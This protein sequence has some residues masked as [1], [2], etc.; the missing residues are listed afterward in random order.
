MIQRSAFLLLIPFLVALAA[1][2][3]PTRPSDPPTWAALTTGATHTCGLSSQGVA[4]CWGNNRFGQLGVDTLLG[5]SI[6]VVSTPRRVQ[7]DLRFKSLSAAEST[8]CGVTTDDVAYC[9]GNNRFGQLGNGAT[10]LAATP[11]PTPV[12]G[13]LTFV[14]VATGGIST[15]AL[16]G[17][18]AAY[19]W[20]DNR[21]GKLGRGDL[22]SSVSPVPVAGGI[23]FTSIHPALL[24]TCGLARDGA[25]YCWGL[26]SFGQ[27]GSGTVT[28]TP[29]LTPIR[30]AGGQTFA[31]LSSGSAYACG[32]RPD[33]SALCWGTNQS[34][35]LGTGSTSASYVPTAVAGGQ[36][37]KT[38]V[39]NR[40]NTIVPHTCGI[41][42]AGTANCWG[43]N[44]TGQ[45]GTAATPQMCSLNLPCAPSPLPVT[46][47][48]TFR[49]VD[50]NANHSCGV[51]TTGEA[52]CWGSTR[53]GQ[54]GNARSGEGVFTAIPVRVPAPS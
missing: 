49:M 8:T 38:V 34:G 48:I 35:N 19:C 47:Q 5:D 28:N 53:F 17:A 52:Y 40:G 39:A 10:S 3:K 4:Y 29:A 30:A 50:V 43:R 31:S 32:I 24:H 46:A 26:N 16:T 45:L 7:S 21:Y 54:L 2:D 36:T 33:S 13:G 42:A 9:W 41:S 14:A 20:G 1:C 12:V 23:A 25:V 37:W 44:E 27:F 18:G 11:A 6:G 15:C 22:A 51:S